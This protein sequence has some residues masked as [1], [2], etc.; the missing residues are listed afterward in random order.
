MHNV[1]RLNDPTTHGGKVITALWSHD[2]AH[3]NAT[4]GFSARYATPYTLQVDGNGTSGQVTVF[5][6]M[7]NAC[8]LPYTNGR[9]ALALSESPIYVVST[10]ASVMKANVTAPAGYVAQ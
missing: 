1:I 4:Q 3:W 7:G 9:I 5:D 8:A 2:N 10:H 6:V